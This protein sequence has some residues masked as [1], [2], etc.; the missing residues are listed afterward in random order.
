MEWFSWTFASR[1]EKTQHWYIIATTV[2]VT[3]VI[4]SFL[5]GE[6]LLGIVL[7]IFAGVYLLYDINSHPDVRINIGANGLSINEDIYDY[8]RMQSFGV[9]RV[10]KKPMILRF[11]TNMKTVGNIDIFIDPAI[12]LSALRLYL[13]TYIPEDAESDIGALERLLLGLRL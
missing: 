12:D 1:F 8:T 11:R 10:D 2:I 9:I 7:I 5:V 6:F 3:A 4:V 13:Q